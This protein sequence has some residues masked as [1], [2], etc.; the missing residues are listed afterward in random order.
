MI[1]DHLILKNMEYGNP[2]G[3]GLLGKTELPA[4]KKQRVERREYQ[5]R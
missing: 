3:E 4:S 1:E 5:K 2:P